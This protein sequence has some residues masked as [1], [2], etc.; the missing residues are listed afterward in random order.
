MGLGSNDELLLGQ[1]GS[2]LTAIDCKSET[3]AWQQKNTFL[4]RAVGSDVEAT[5]SDQFSSRPYRCSWLRSVAGI[6]SHYW[7]SSSDYRA[8]RLSSKAISISLGVHL[9]PK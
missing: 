9:S 1:L 8:E 4:R 7:R 5:E 6:S 3:V 2:H